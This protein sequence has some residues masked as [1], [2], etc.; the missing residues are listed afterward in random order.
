VAKTYLEQFREDAGGAYDD[1]SDQ[2][3]A[4]A[5]HR[6]YEAE[7]GNTADFDVFAKEIGFAKQESFLEYAG[8]VYADIAQT[9]KRI[10]DALMGIAS[11]ISQDIVSPDPEEDSFLEVIKKT[12]ENIP[13]RFGR[14]VGGAM[15]AMGGEDSPLNQLIAPMFNVRDI[16]DFGR[17]AGQAIWQRSTDAIQANQPNV[18]PGSP[19][20]Y[21]AGILGAMIE[22]GPALTASFIAKDPNIGIAIMSGQVYGD[23]FGEAIAEG[24]SE[25]RAHLDGVFYAATEGLT[26]K[27]PLGVLTKEGGK[28][29]GRTLKSA[30]AEGLQEVF[31]EA[32]QI[33]WERGIWKEGEE[34][35]LGQLMRRLWDAAIIGMGAGGGLAIITQPAI[36]SAEKVIG[37]EINE[38]VKQTELT[39]SEF[40][41]IDKFSPPQNNAQAVLQE[42]IKEQPQIPGISAKIEQVVTPDKFGP[43]VSDRRA[44]DRGVE[45]RTDI[46]GRRRVAE[47]SPAELK[48]ALLTDELTGIK[49][50]RAYE[51][52][53][54]LP[55]QVSIDADSL[56]WVNDNM[57]HQAG[58]EFLRKIG[59]TI[60]SVTENAYHIS[61]DEFMVEAQTTEEAQAIM[62]QVNE[63][64]K[65][66]TLT[67][68]KPDGTVIEKTGLEITFGLGETKAESDFA[69]EEEKG[70][71]EKAGLR[72]PRK[73]QPPG[74]AIQQAEEKPPTKETAAKK[75]PFEMTAKEW[76]EARQA[77]RPENVQTDLT[78]ASAAQAEARITELERLLFGV[79]DADIARLN[80]ARNGEIKLTAKE[81]AEIQERIDTPILHRDIIEK[82]ISE[83]KKIPAEVLAEYPDLKPKPAKKK[84]KKKPAK[85]KGD[86]QNTLKSVFEP[87]E[88]YVPMLRGTEVKSTAVPQEPIRREHIIKAIE[89]AFGLRVYRGRVKG[90]TRLGFFR[91]SN[92]EVRTKY[93]NDLEIT[94]H[95]F[96]HWIDDRYPAFKKAYNKS[97]YKAELQGISYDVNDVE[98]G[99]AEFGRLYMTQE[100]E[101]ALKAPKFYDKFLEIMASEGITEKV[102]DIKDRMHGWYNQGSLARF[103]SKIGKQPEPLRQRV[104]TAVDG[105]SDHSIAAIFDQLHGLKVAEADLTGDIADADLSPY[106]NAR[107]VAGSRGVM[108]AVLEHGTVNWTAEGDLYFTG[109]GLREI[110]E[111]VA[112]NFDNAMTYFAARRANELMK[113]GREHHFEPAE[114]K[115]ALDLATPAIEKAHKEYQAF[116]RRMMDFY[117]ASGLVNSESRKAMEEMNKDYVPFF[118]IQEE[119]T[120]EVVTRRTPFKRL[121][122][123]TANVDDIFDNI[124]FGTATLIQQALINKAKQQAYNMVSSSKNGA[125]YAVKIPTDIKPTQ[126]DIKQVEDAFT[127]G[128]GLKNYKR[129]QDPAIDAMLDMIT[130]NLGDFINFFTFGHAPRGGNIDSV[131]IEGKQV[132]YEV[133]DPLFLRA[134]TSFGPR[135]MGLILRVMGGF[136]NTLTRGVTSMPDFQ[137]IN[138]LR[139]SF[140]GFALSQGGITPVIDSAKGMVDR[141]MK[142]DAYW[143][144]M[145]NGGG[146]ASTVH[147][148]TQAARRHLERLYTDHGIDYKTVIDTPQKMLDMW[149]EFTSAFEYGT[150]LAEY[151]ALRKKGKSMRE[152]AFQGR[153]I[154]TDFAM[155]GYSD[156]L[157]VFTS[158]V[159]FLNARM[160][161]LYRLER[162]AFE[163]KGRQVPWGKHA[164]RLAA[165]GM[166]ALT[167]PSLILYLL[168]RDD[169]RYKAL[170]EWVR[171][172]HWVIFVPGVESPFLIP[173]PFEV[174]AIF[175]TIPERSL[176]LAIEKNGDRFG[177]AMKHVL[178][179]TFNMNPTPQMIKP[180]VETEMTNRKFT[181]APIIPDDLKDIEATEQY[182]PWSSES[183]V[184]L[185]K[186]TGVAPL[187]L[188]HWVRGYLGTLGMY[189]LM[190]SDGLVGDKFGGEVPTRRI[191]QIPVIRRFLRQ[192]PYRGTRYETEF[193]KLAEETRKVTKTFNKIRDEGRDKD[194]NQYIGSKDREL[195]FGI[196]GSVQEVTRNA[197]QINRAMRQIRI[198]KNMTADVKQKRI[199][200]LQEQK[201]QLFSIATKVLDKR[202]LRKVKDQLKRLE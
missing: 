125:L 175:A 185:G 95:E 147:G 49:S 22:M 155:R 179:D 133:A 54:R 106:K 120:G 132:F 182:R 74:V 194:L 131:M 169:E 96:T 149:D 60:E 87:G 200:E 77:V 141:L 70:A 134:M 198:D 40:D 113:Q 195:L 114:I 196:A 34:L 10:N 68:T 80:A 118:R 162:E 56:A 26:E 157:R 27:I 135:P 189:L 181:G 167:I 11:A 58:D 124:T 13:E 171:D 130:G 55:V 193:Y 28:W 4:I 50:R 153:E 2:D 107:L 5:L 148:E 90:K 1:L 48:K 159:P 16:D 177:E 51:D 176:E 137:L 109:K 100:H 93:H 66:E 187:K 172:L 151:K 91:K 97:P 154:S 103:R 111:P 138:L 145:A 199:N 44:G 72:A 3:L 117:E 67:A 99:F 163:A 39:V 201:N 160:Q 19:K 144:Y 63:K 21:T 42:A 178:F 101:A 158:T 15:S 8:G 143:E 53:P 164:G 186:K 36:P 59:Q 88:T 112:D 183:M 69:M 110:F 46:D 190:G 81:A 6:K 85:K 9:P 62:A 105:L 152:A 38:L 64:L 92:S 52:A 121:T 14:A 116:N 146:Y 128:L 17:E 191:D 123:G 94:A 45:R 115:A 43:V 41:V 29:L 79:R 122:G 98:E 23:K 20:Y 142:D 33:G 57:G 18:K 25:G 104:A 30:G 188:E 47:M 166:L 150:R 12:T 75:E 102:D 35:T 89:K 65:N 7:T 78:K 184:E 126:V 202:E 127:K 139:D 24:K 31:A 168:N 180:L 71:R 84:A 108:K 173:K 76:R 174:G 165:R 197:A 83:G 156:F 170:P 61:G 32:M 136:K 86:V 82:A 140:N 192:A 119:M 129:G 73:E 161:G 37:N